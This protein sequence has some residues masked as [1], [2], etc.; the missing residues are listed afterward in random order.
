MTARD[1]EPGDM[2]HKGHPVTVDRYT[3]GAPR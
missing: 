1:I 3:A 2:V